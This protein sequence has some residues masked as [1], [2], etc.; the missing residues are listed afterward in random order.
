MQVDFLTM[1]CFRDQLDGLLGARVQQVILPD[2]RSVALELYAGKRVNL[3]ASTDPQASRMLLVPEKPR[4]GVDIQT[5]FLLLLRKWV[6]GARLVDVTQPPWE[7]VLVLHLSGRAG[8]CRLVAELMGRYS[9]IVLVGGDGTVLDAIKH[10]TSSMSRYRTTLPGQPYQQPPPPKDRSPP[11][12]FAEEG[13]ADK[14]MQAPLDEPLH[15]W[16]I[17]Q[18]LGVSRVAAREIAV[19]A[20]GDAAAPVRACTPQNIAAAVRELFVPLSDGWWTPH[21]ALDEAGS[22]IAFTP[23]K[24]RQFA[25][26]EPAPDISHAMW[27]FFEDRGMTDPYAAARKSVGD[28]ITDANRRLENRLSNL[29]EEVGDEVKLSDLRIAGE[30]LL[31]YQNQVPAGASEVSLCGYDGDPRIV[32]L[33]PELTPVENAQAYFRRYEKM[34]RAAKHIPGLV[35]KL[36]SQRIYLDQLESDLALAESRPEIDAIRESLAAAG[37]APRRR[38]KM[39]A[40]VSEP[41]RFEVGGFRI[42]VGRNS[43]QNEQITF[44]HAGPEDL[45]LH[46]RG[47]PGAHVVIRRGRQEVPEDIVLRAAGLAAYYSRARDSESQ[48]AVDVTERRFVR[49]MRGRHPGMVTYRNE[50]TVWVTD[51]EIQ[52]WAADIF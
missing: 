24:P 8:E 34:R 46:A 30:L 48:V 38:R 31:T 17:S 39:A 7:R 35:E 28:L 4:R 26:T 16:L 13:W 47:L 40:Q 45:W 19:R 51:K 32:A 12:I 27:R 3:Y 21:V 6:R 36:E 2:S 18:L 11:T 15:Q 50:R 5:P 52:E 29:R 25:R 49:R 43:R 42:Y 23:Y 22:V 44:K 1:A 20:T 33:N 41:R 9:N 14:L 37:W 10:V